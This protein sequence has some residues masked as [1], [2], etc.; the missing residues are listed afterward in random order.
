M[1]FSHPAY[2]LF[3]ALASW[4]WHAARS[5]PAMRR[6]SAIASRCGVVTLLVLSAAG[7]E[8]RAGEEPLSVLFLVDRSDSMAGA[9]PI[10]QLNASSAGARAADRSGVIVFGANAV[11]E[12]RLAP[13]RPLREIASDV[14][15]SGTNIEAALRLARA[16]LPNGGSRRIVLISDGRETTGAAR[17]EA[18]RL[19]AD[20]VSIDVVEPVDRSNATRPPR[21]VAV[22]A[23]ASVRTGEPFV[24]VAD[25]D[26][27]PRTRVQVWLQRDL[28]PA[29]VQEA[30]VSESGRA[31]VAFHDQHRSTGLRVYRASVRAADDGEAPEDPAA[32]AV[33]SVAGA[34]HVLYVSTSAGVLSATLAANDFRVTHRSPSSVPRAA[35][36]LSGYDAI[37]LD[38]VAA[39]E[40]DA[41]QAT[42]IAQHVEQRG[43]GLLMLGSA[44]SL[45]AGGVAEGPLGPVL[46]IDLRPRSGR[47]SPAVALV[48]LFD[49]SGSMADR[50]GGV[51]KIQIARQSV[52]KV[53]GV[54]PSTDALGVIAFDA[55][56]VA[57]APLAAG[58]DARAM[59]DSLRSVDAGGATRIAPAMQLARDWLQTPA[60]AGST[61]RHVLLVS[62]GRTTAEDAARVETMVRTGGFE[63]SVV[64]LGPESDQRLLARLASV[65]GGRAYFPEDLAQLPS[66]L[67]REASRVTGGRLVEERFT[68]R[69]SA[70]PVAAGLERHAMPQMHGYVVSASKPAAETILRSHLDDPILAGWRFGLGRAAAF[71]ADLRG[72]WSADMRAWSGFAPLWVQSLRWLSRTSNAD[73]LHVTF[74]RVANE[75]HLVVEAEDG[76]A[77]FLNSL[78]GRVYA[79]TP[80]GEMLELP[81][82]GVAPGRY[83]AEIPLK[84]PGPYAV[85]IAARNQQ[86]TLEQRLVR[87]F[88]WSADAEHLNHG[89]D[90][91]ALRQLAEATGGSML[92][93]GQSVFARSRAPR[94]V[95]MWPWLTAAALLLFVLEVVG[96]RAWPAASFRLLAGRGAVRAHV[97]QN[98]A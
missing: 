61:K 56:P 35:H 92:E 82:R 60:G 52:S 76:E 63:L 43:G 1:H 37:V 86:G 71:T 18:A 33:V 39:S 15:S 36:A 30:T 72:P 96:A 69:T 83:V 66:I 77:R 85:T 12:R 10:E 29:I 47:R 34:A 7:L 14:V 32:G 42:A 31:A 88:Y 6:G 91:I 20:G 27:A 17:A 8:V 48:L 4:F 74:E 44:G 62:D 73:G 41:A 40:L 3:L 2:L 98:L 51:P 9:S 89:A 97:D 68:I 28:D 24:V 58:H 21:V 57:I 80:A 26:A 93:A 13:V 65:T 84:D 78:K 11:L 94:Y 25:V 67:A 95:Q 70:H 55:V 45:E 19:V 38:E 5:A 64:A 46:P 50:A 59:A 81:L 87:G 53:L 16:T 22:S 75:M 54:L 49:K 23:P 90:V 79:R